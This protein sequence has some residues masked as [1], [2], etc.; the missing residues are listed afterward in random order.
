MEIKK[1]TQILLGLGGLVTIGAIIWWASFYDQV[2]KEMGGN[3]GDFFQCLYTSS[4]P[5]S[6]FIGIARLSG[7]TPYNPTVF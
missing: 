2:I 5:C 4:G 3:L 6:L 1:L 7:V